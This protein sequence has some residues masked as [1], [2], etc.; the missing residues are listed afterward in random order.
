MKSLEASGVLRRRC[1]ADFTTSHSLY[2]C[3][4]YCDCSNNNI[5]IK[6]YY[7]CDV[8]VMY[9]I[10]V[11]ILLLTHNKTSSNCCRRCWYCYLLKVHCCVS[12][13]HIFYPIYLL[14]YV[15]MTCLLWSS[16]TISLTASLAI[17]LSPSSSSLMRQC[18]DVYVMCHI[19]WLYVIRVNW[20]LHFVA[21]HQIYSHCSPDQYGFLQE[22][23][24]KRCR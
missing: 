21:S 22:N 14:R 5:I 8:Q 10:H 11:F 4:I 18:T 6:C 7:Y 3:I 24:V 13:C 16:S 19:Y 17:T 2:I 1:G 15:M 9:F 23:R 20:F 12:D